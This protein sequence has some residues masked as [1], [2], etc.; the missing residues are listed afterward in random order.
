[1]LSAVPAQPAAPE[2]PREEAF[3]HVVEDAL[4]LDGPEALA[5][6]MQQ[7]S[8]DTR[9]LKAQVDGLA[10]EASEAAQNNRQYFT[11]LT[12]VENAA[13]HKIRETARLAAET[14]S[15]R[16]VFGELRRL[17]DKAGGEPIPWEAVTAALALEP[18]EPSY[19]PATLA[20]LP[21]EQFR[22]GQFAAP[23]GDVTLVFTF[24]G[25]AL[26]DHGPGAYGK[27]EPMFLVEDRALPRSVIEYERHVR[28][29]SYL[30]HLERMAS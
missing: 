28:F 16:S 8:G 20:F 5:R 30:P 13:S 26:I 17:A 9:A 21:S 24:I 10:Q 3:R 11:M 27:V 25:W 4:Q 6:I 12:Q 1:M 14:A 2:Q 7:Y 19:V 23:A 18:M 22:G 29:E 15:L